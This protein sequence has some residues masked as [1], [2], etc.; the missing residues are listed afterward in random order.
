MCRALAYLGEPALVDD[1]LFQPDS[2]LVRQTY[3]PQMLGMLNLAGF[4]MTVWD[5]TSYRPS[6]PFSYKS[7]SL[8]IFDANLKGL[9]LKLRASC[10]LA[11][12]RGVHYHA[13]A[14]ISPQNLHPFRFEG[15]R[16]AMAHNGELDRF[17]EMRFALV[18]RMKPEIAQLIRGNT[19]SEFIYALLLSQF[20]DP[21]GAPSGEQ[22]VSAVSRTLKV[23]RTVRDDYG[24]RTMSPVNLF[25]A[26]GNT[27][28]GVRFIFDY[29]CYP[30]A[31]APALEPV[32][33][34][35]LSLWYTLGNG[36]G[37]HDGEWKM[38]GSKL[39][40]VLLASEPL[41]RDLSLWVEV[42]E[43]SLVWVDRKA[44]TPSAATVELDV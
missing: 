22:I 12:V 30:Y 14:T 31:A 43:Y 18:E 26:D 44:G 37:L 27:L 10:L 33:L 9:A 35:Y 29:G 1:F 25:I 38:L 20:D 42:P 4:G 39:D 5:E 11:H 17:D 15:F 2:S 3:D 32:S 41:S 24:I 36:F 23:L 7:T 13:G 34:H 28:A 21:T 6:L 8:P 19:D 40:S 16:L